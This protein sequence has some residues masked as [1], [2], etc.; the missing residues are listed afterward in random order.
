VCL[1]ILHYCRLDGDKRMLAGSQ[2]LRAKPLEE[3]LEKFA[4]VARWYSLLYRK[5]IPCCG[6]YRQLVQ[7]SRIAMSVAQYAAEDI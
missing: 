4:A 5:C 7:S 3:V 1:D 2:T 6:K